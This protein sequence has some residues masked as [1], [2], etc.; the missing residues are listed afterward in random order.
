MKVVKQTK[1]WF[2]LLDDQGYQIAEFDMQ[3]D[4]DLAIKKVNANWQKVYV[5]RFNKNNDDLEAKILSLY[6]AKVDGFWYQSTH[7]NYLN[8][9]ATAGRVNQDWFPTRKEASEFIIR[10]LQEI[11]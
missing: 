6:V 3:D 10:K 11:E 1:E 9:R 5:V 8:M 2:A 7:A 4:V